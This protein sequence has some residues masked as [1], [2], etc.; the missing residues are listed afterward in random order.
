MGVLI[1]MIAN[2]AVAYFVYKGTGGNFELAAAAFSAIAA[3]NSMILHVAFF[4]KK[5]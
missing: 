4:L 1:S 2:T 5:A 3:I